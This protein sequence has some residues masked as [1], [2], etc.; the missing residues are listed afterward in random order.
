MSENKPIRLC[1]NCYYYTVVCAKINNEP[2]DNH[3]FASE[4]KNTFIR[5]GDRVE[6]EGMHG[7]VIYIT[8]I[9]AVA[10]QLALV[11]GKLY[12]AKLSEQKESNGAVHQHIRKFDD[13]LIRLGYVRLLDK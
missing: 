11:A 7:E 3:K 4:V 6:I 2:C 12:V 13:H 8:E 10:K 5:I 1:S 9:Y